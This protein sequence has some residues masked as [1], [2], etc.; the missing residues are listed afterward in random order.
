MLSVARNLEDGRFDGA[1][2][3]LLSAAWGEVAS[4]AVV[5]PARVPGHVRVV[6]V[7]G[8]TLGGSGKTPLAI[9][10]ARELARQGARVVLVGHAYRASPGRARVVSGLDSVREVGD[11]ALVAACALEPHGV[12]VVVAPSRGAAVELGARVADVLVLDGTLQ[13]SP[14]RATLA[15]LAVDAEEPWGRAAAVP[16][17]GD[18]RAPV[19]ALL[20]AADVL[21]RVGDDSPDVSVRSAGAFL[22]GALLP[23][24][25][26]RPL[27]VGLASALARP[28][29]LLRFLARRGVVP[30]ATA[31][32][33]DHAPIPARALHGRVDLWLTTAKC[34]LHVASAGAPLATLDHVVVCSPTLS[35]KL[36]ASCLDPRLREQ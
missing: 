32:G 10:C 13:L 22:D 1:V 23:W 20:A 5:R 14:R 16:P 18:L 31:L 28:R 7:G 6:T 21:V 12:D 4:R 35:A 36:S 8:A 15:L 19:A 30:C 27:R 25:T 2:A 17:R 3:R 9:A 34:A 24:E 29:R 33:G 11:E 26:L